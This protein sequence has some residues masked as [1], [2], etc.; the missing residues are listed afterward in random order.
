[1][2]DLYIRSGKQDHH[3]APSRKMYNLVLVAYA[4]SSNGDDD[5]VNADNVNRCIALIDRMKTPGAPVKPVAI[6]YN[7]LLDAYSR[8][9]DADSAQQ[10][11]EELERAWESSGGDEDM[12]PCVVSYSCALSA[13]ERSG[14]PNAAQKAEEIVL[15][16]VDL[17]HKTGDKR[18]APN[19][20]T[21]GT[22]IAL[23]AQNRYDRNN[24]ENAERMLDWLIQ[25]HREN[26]YSEDTAPNG[27][28]FASVLNA[29]SK[30]RRRDSGE[31]VY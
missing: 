26:G 17:Y 9:G 3:L 23:H 16:M 10:I 14:D 13:W 18:V 24:V 7:V 30:S 4:K 20:I 15:R 2:E 27:S 22:C 8:L 21:L 11:L 25:I 28:H 6:S 29:W 31:F 1:M 5:V 19:Q 12:M